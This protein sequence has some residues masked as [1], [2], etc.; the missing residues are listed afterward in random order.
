[1]SGDYAY[2]NANIDKIEEEDCVCRAISVGLSIPYLAVEKLLDIVS[3]YYGCD[4]LQ[5]CCY[6]H[7]MEDIFNVPVR[8]C[9]YGETVGEI[10]EQYPNNKV[11]IRIDGHLTCSVHGVICDIWRCNEK[12]ADC[13]WII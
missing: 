1:M 9:Q 13:Y 12:E 5:K 7:I 8:Y 4:P 11:I 3:Y 10:A 6:H 2:Y